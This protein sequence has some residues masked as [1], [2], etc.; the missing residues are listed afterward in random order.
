MT[1]QTFVIRKF[2]TEYDI[3]RSELTTLAIAVIDNPSPLPTAKSSGPC[4]VRDGTGSM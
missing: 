1:D 2:V 4:N 3:W